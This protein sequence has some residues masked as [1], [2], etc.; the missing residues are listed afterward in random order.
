MITCDLCTAPDHRRKVMMHHVI[1][2]EGASIH[3]HIC[4]ECATAI[5]K[6]I[7]E[8]P[9]CE[10]TPPAPPAGDA[11]ILVDAINAAIELL[12]EHDMVGGGLITAIR[13]YAKGTP[14]P[15]V[16]APDAE[17]LRKLREV[18]KAANA[19]R[20]QHWKGKMGSDGYFEVLRD[21][22]VALDALTALRAAKSAKEARGG[23]TE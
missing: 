21:L 20:D 12:G 6:R 13:E 10:P 23:E 8:Q 1:K 16:A 22:W 2:R 3:L 7:A 4:D 19:L 11:R 15:P 9:G 14:P 5:G 17:E 18:A